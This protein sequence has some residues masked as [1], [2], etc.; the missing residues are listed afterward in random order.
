MRTIDPVR[1]RAAY[2]WASLVLD[3]AGDHPYDVV[4]AAEIVEEV[5]RMEAM[6]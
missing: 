6:V 1:D 3:E 2:R 4:A 5:I